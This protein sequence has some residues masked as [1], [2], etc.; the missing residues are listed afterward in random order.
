[1]SSGLEIV[2]LG[3]T[4]KAHYSNA[5]K[6]M[7]KCEQHYKAA[8]IHLLEAQARIKAGEY[9]KPF[10]HYCLQVVGLSASRCYE[11]ISIADGR[12]T[13]EEIREDK[14]QSMRRSR[15]QSPQRGG[16]YQPVDP[17]QKNPKTQQSRTGRP[18]IDVISNLNKK[19]RDAL[20]HKDEQ[21]LLVILNFI[22]GV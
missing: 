2:Q 11:L 15:E 14:A 19:I 22:K 12:K 13:L 9:G 6:Y 18:A 3:S 4:I 8:G 17:Q 1:M 5:E 21:Q 7:D 16:Q 20:K 10:S